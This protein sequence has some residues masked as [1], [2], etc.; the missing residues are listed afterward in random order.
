MANT[1]PFQFS[2]K[3][4]DPKQPSGFTLMGQNQMASI[5]AQLVSHEATIATLQA[6]I[7]ALQKAIN[8]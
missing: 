5:Q 7:A 3:Y 1:A 2:V 4:I 8:P 6:Q